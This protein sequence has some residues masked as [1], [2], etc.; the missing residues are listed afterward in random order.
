MAY[1]KLGVC[2]HTSCPHGWKGAQAEHVIVHRLLVDGGMDCDV[3]AALEGKR[4]MQDALMDALRARIE[5]VREA[6]MSAE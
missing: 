5:K 6:D 3:A 1:T 2:N 4:D